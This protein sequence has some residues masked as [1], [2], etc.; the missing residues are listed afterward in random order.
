MGAN[1]QGLF[2]FQRF[3]GCD[4]VG[5]KMKKYS[6]LYFIIHWGFKFMGIYEISTKSK[7]NWASTKSDD[8]IVLVLCQYLL[9]AKLLCRQNRSWNKI[10]KSLISVKNNIVHEY[11]FYFS[12]CYLLRDLTGTIGWSLHCPWRTGVSS[13]WP[14]STSWA[15]SLSPT[16]STTPPTSPQGRLSVG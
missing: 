13:G 14:S 11:L 9:T 6:V 15:T 2:I 4:F 5:S 7:K 8:L 1:F 10:K 12:T 3:L 16:S